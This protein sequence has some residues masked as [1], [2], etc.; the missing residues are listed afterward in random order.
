[1]FARAS[2]RRCAHT[3][4]AVHPA[5]DAWPLISAVEDL[6]QRLETVADPEVERLRSRAEASLARA[7]AALAEEAARSQG[8]AE[9]FA[10]TG[11]GHV[12]PWALLAVA[13]VCAIVVGVLSGRAMMD[14]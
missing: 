10:E 3:R 8:A 2:G 11:E 4:R 9:E 7:K 14:G 1:M 13:A 12:R 5:D 6:V